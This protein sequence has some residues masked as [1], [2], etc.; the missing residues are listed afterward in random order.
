[1]GGCFIS[2]RRHQLTYSESRAPAAIRLTSLA[3]SPPRVLVMPLILLS[4]H[5]VEH[6]HHFQDAACKYKAIGHRYTVLFPLLP[7]GSSPLSRRH[8]SSLPTIVVIRFCY[9]LH[10]AG[11]LSLSLCN[12][13]VSLITP[14]LSS[15]RNAQFL[16]QNLKAPP[17]TSSHFAFRRH[18]CI[19][20][21]YP[22]CTVIS[23]KS[24]DRRPMP[25]LC[26]KIE[27]IFIQ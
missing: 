25:S 16:Y 11:V 26:Y 15:R 19:R 22:L 9:N 20:C 23:C 17:Q 5:A 12:L 24:K 27:K 21:E 18:G 7:L 14:P 3:E 10:A 6:H 8:L 4:L 1:M 13:W 2:S